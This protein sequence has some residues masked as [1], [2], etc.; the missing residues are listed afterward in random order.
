MNN[1]IKVSRDIIPVFVGLSFVFSL[2][3]N[4]GF[5]YGLGLDIGSIPVSFADITNSAIKASPGAVIIL[6]LMLHNFDRYSLTH[7]V[8]VNRLDIADDRI[9][10]T[11]N[12]RVF[13]VLLILFFGILAFFTFFTFYLWLYILNV[14]IALKLVYFWDLRNKQFFKF[15]KAAKLIMLVLILI[16]ASGFYFGYQELNNTVAR[17][18]ITLTDETFNSNVISILS[19]GIF[20]KKHGDV[21]FISFN[22]IVQIR[23]RTRAEIKADAIHKS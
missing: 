7:A 6:L 11:G 22:R 9:E 15:Y 21:C 19:N 1:F 3:F 5:Y 23:Y 12:S 17:Q 16:N 20:I 10:S 2:I 14:L 18:Q 8:D 13:N 4:L